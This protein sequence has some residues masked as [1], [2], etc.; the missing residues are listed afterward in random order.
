MRV[1]ALAVLL[2]FVVG[3]ASAPHRATGQ[4]PESTERYVKVCAFNLLVGLMLVPSKGI[5]AFEQPL[6]EEND[7]TKGV[8]L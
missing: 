2:A 1:L 3:C 4:K 7:R 8:Q 6:C 5:T